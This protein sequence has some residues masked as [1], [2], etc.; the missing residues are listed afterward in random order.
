MR[1]LLALTLALWMLAVPALAQSPAHETPA[2]PADIESLAVEEAQAADPASAAEDPVEPAEDALEA[3]SVPEDAAD[4]DGAGE[5][6]L[7]ENQN[8]DEASAA[9]SPA[10]TSSEGEPT[11]S[12]TDGSDADLPAVEDEIDVEA[13]KHKS[14]K[15]WLAAQPRKKKKTI[16]G[17]LKG[18]GIG[19]GGALLA[20]KDPLA[21]AAIG[22]VAGA[23]AGYLVGRRQDKLFASRDQ[24]IEAIG[25]EP[26]QGYVMRVEE[27]RFDPPNLEPG[28][29]SE[30]YVKYIVVGPQPKEKIVV[31]T[32]TGIRYDEVYIG[33][34][35]PKKFTVPRGGGIVESTITVTLPKDAPG[36]SYMVQAQVED[37]GGR[38][39]NTGEGPVYVEVQEEEEGE[40]GEEGESTEA[41]TST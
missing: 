24:A 2:E 13:K 29:S 20:G 30:M 33:G 31:H 11:S 18:A 25:Y 41:A 28:G 26:S 4:Q 27:V 15:A 16:M 23:L 35:G 39:E 21:G 34:G 3:D 36:G 14:P 1:K 12:V 6:D 7:E 17:A 32:Y 19:L 9:T 5:Q 22:A 40:E 10:A 37:A 38:F 8:L